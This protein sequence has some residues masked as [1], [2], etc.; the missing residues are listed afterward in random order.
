[1]A[2]RVKLMEAVKTEIVRCQRCDGMNIHDVTQAAP[3]YG[4]PD[5]PV[6]VVGQSLCASPA[7]EPR[8]VTHVSVACRH[9][10]AAAVR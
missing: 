5:S 1:M 2:S 4:S 10:P 3:G 7:C 6:V 8:S 9:T